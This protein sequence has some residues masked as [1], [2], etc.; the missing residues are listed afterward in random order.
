MEWQAGALA[1]QIRY[2]MSE[3][4]DRQA[5]EIGDQRSEVRGRRSEIG[6]QRSKVRGRTR[7]SLAVISYQL[8][9]IG[10]KRGEIGAD[11]T[12]DVG[13]LFLDDL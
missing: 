5:R 11:S 8:S 1:L 12:A 13:E 4:K 10:F 7:Q 6:D 9:V 3:D 2:Q